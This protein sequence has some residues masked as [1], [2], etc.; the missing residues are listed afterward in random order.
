MGRCRSIL[1]SCSPQKSHWPRASA[2]TVKLVDTMT[3]PAQPSAFVLSF[4]VSVLSH[5]PLR[6]APSLPTGNVVEERR[7]DDLKWV[8]QVVRDQGTMGARVEDAKGTILPSI[9]LEDL[10][11]ELDRTRKG[12]STDADLRS[13]VKDVG[14][15]TTPNS[16]P[17]VV[18]EIQRRLARGSVPVQP[19]LRS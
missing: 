5:C 9:S 13:F 2:S 10:F 17:T 18:S 15:P 16:V 4:E 8:L 3:V 11:N 12:C 1:P 7:V 6:S 14:G 19:Q